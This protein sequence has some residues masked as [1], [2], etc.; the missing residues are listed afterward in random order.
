[1]SQ[2]ACEEDGD[3]VGATESEP[4]IYQ[5]KLSCDNADLQNCKYC[6]SADATECQICEEGYA[7]DVRLRS[8]TKGK[9][10]TTSD[11]YD[12]GDKVEDNADKTGKVCQLPPCTD[13]HCQVCINSPGACEKCDEGYVVDVREPSSTNWPCILT[14]ECTDNAAPSG[15][16][17][18]CE[19][20]G[21]IIYVDACIDCRED[22][23]DL[24]A[25]CEDGFTLTDDGTEC[26]ED[27]CMTGKTAIE[28]CTFCDP[29]EDPMKCFR[30]EHGYSPNGAGTEC[31][32]NDCSSLENC[33]VCDLVR[34]AGW[35]DGDPLVLTC[36]ECSEGSLVDKRNSS[37]TKGACVP[38]ESCKGM[39]KPGV[40][41]DTGACVDKGCAAVEYCTECD[42]EDETACAGCEKGYSVES[43]DCKEKDCQTLENCE[44]CDTREGS[45]ELECLQC[46]EGYL[47]DQRK[48]SSLRGTCLS[49]AACNGA[50]KVDGMA[51]VDKACLEVDHCTGCDA[52]NEALCIT[53]EDGYMLSESEGA[54][55]CK[56]KGLSGGAIAGIAI[57]VI[58]VVAL[59]VFLCVWFLV[60]RK[61]KAGAVA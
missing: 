4:A 22:N 9:C 40:D 36:V 60:C 34:P 2:R 26:L 12:E 17:L 11:C 48:A 27:D 25:E 59:V 57:A 31:V 47:I 49:A 61:K 43:G 13:E 10:I 6:E 41:K 50:A 28:H 7:L 16:G 32:E 5:D 46:K 24:C 33:T 35:E 42:T 1:M 30:C 44:L 52:E 29:Y 23:M 53:C 38:S 18:R 8:R 54:Q 56:K 51:C 58:V 55:E 45:T 19:H 14:E 15:D 20:A 21:C 3:Y 39:A 37:D